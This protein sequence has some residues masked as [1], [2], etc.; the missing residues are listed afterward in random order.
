MLAGS[1]SRATNGQV[2]RWLEQGRPALRID[3][4]ALARGEAVAD[5]ALAFATGHDEP[6][7]IYA[8]S[9]PDEVRAVQAELG[10]ERAGHLVEQCLATV[11]A[12]LLARGTRRFVVA[13]GETSGAVVQALGVRALRI[14]AQ[15]A[16]G[17]PATVTLDAK[18]LALALKSGNFGGA[19][20]FDEALR[21]L[22]GQP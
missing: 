8:T 20:F 13:G 6:V 17:V 14:G 4:L 10:V 19:D 3:P 15:I 5:A 11:A 1:A 9:S 18:P 22:G 2:A 16:P 21:Q 12:G 7:L